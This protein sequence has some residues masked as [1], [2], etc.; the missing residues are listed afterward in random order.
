MAQDEIF[1]GL[2]QTFK[3]NTD[4]TLR[5]DVVYFVPHPVQFV[6]NRSPIRLAKSS[7][8]QKKIGKSLEE[9]KFTKAM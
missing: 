9:I 1:H 2:P 6:N 7:T 5:S 4:V 3:I 8:T